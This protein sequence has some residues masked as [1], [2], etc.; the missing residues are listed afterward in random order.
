LRHGSAKDYTAIQIFMKIFV[1]SSACV[2]LAEGRKPRAVS[3]T[4]QLTDPP[5][6]YHGNIST[7]AFADSHAEF[8][9]WT[10]PKLIAAGQSEARGNHVPYATFQPNNLGKSALN[11]YSEDLGQ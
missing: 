7:S 9:K 3:S 1:T 10:D 11:T 5:V 8:H 2:L 6:M 4:F